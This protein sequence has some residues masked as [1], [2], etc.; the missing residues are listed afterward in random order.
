MMEEHAGG[1]VCKCP[2]HKMP[3]VFIVL[4]G[5]LFLGGNLGWWGMGVVNVGWPVLVI[6]AG[7]MHFGKGWCKC[8]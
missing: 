7:L 5:L 3:G 4:F 6:L 8:C 2:H 1:M